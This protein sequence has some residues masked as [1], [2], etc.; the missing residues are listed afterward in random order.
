MASAKWTEAELD[1]SVKVYL[2]MLSKESNG[3]PYKKSEYRNQ[4]LESVLKGRT[5]GSFEFR[6]QNI[7][8]V[9]LS[10]G[11]P[12]IKGYLPAKNVGTNTIGSIAQSLEKN[13]FMLLGDLGPTPDNEQLQ[14]RTQRIR[15]TIDL[16]EKPTGQQIPQKIEYTTSIYY[17]DPEVRAWVLEMAKGKCEACHTDAPFVQF[18]GAPFLEVHHMIPLASGGPD[19]TENTIALCPNCHRKVHLSK[20]R[21]IFKNEIY[22]KVER[23]IK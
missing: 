21:D 5:A 13:R 10:L 6:M 23:L 11:Q 19:T 15:K 7:S 3:T 12:Y 17:R 2:E 20:D 18:D 8:Y 16:K 14:Q 9:L 4:L 1:A 22:H